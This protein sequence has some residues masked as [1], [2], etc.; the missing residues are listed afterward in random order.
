MALIPRW[1][2]AS[3]VVA[4]CCGLA[5]DGGLVGGAKA[6]TLPTTLDKEIKYFYRAPS[7][8][9]VAKILKDF[10]KPPYVGN[11]ASYPPLAGFLAA[12]FSR[13]PGS[14]NAV[15]TTDVDP[16]V[17][18]SVAIGL[19]LAGQAQKA[20]AVAARMQAAGL[21]SPELDKLPAS[22]GMIRAQTPSD[23]DLLW[24]ASSA[25]GDSRY[26]LVIL[27][28]FRSY[29][30]E[31]NNA[32]VLVA[33]E[34]EVEKGPKGDLHWVRQQW[35]NAKAI[36]LIYMASALWGLRSNAAQHDFVR[37]AIGQYIAAHPDEPA[38]RALVG[39]V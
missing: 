26:C 39:K 37:A 19:R 30:N 11:A 13:Y 12:F 16:R 23:F 20:E 3:I 24:G 27:D 34:K 33:I 7:T 38:A 29:A 15:V 22:L 25:T 28:A 2:V 9:A 14:V 6:Q 32:K 1:I 8:E 18:W 10:S 31:G 21:K 5:V 35:G 36:E 4:A 17:L